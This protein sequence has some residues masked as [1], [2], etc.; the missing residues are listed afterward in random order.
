MTK[1]NG[2]QEQRDDTP[3]ADTSAKEGA[4]TQS[5]VPVNFSQTR[6]TGRREGCRV[7][8]S[9]EVSIHLGD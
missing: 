6:E 9:R 2:G 4:E 3:Q 5:G 8:T 1:H 7:F